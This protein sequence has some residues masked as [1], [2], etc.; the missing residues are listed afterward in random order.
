MNMNDIYINIAAISG[1]SLIKKKSWV[2]P[3]Y[4]EKTF[5]ISYD[6]TSMMRKKYGV[7]LK[8]ITSCLSGTNNL[9]LVTTFMLE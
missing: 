4:C 8:V 3:N 7:L 9:F 6:I 2:V 1:I 5:A